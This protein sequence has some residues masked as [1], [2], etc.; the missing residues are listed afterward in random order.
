MIDFDRYATLSN[1]EDWEAVHAL[2][3]D[4]RAKAATADDRSREIYL[5]VAALKRQHR[6][7]EALDLLRSG[8]HLYNSQSLAQHDTAHV[9][10]KLGCEQDALNVL[11][12]APYETEMTSFPLLAMDAKFFHLLLLAKGGD[13]SVKARLGEIPDDY[14]HV[15]MDGD[16]VR[17][18]DIIAL[19][20][21]G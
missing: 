12:K 3:D 11:S 9:L 6:Y 21:D 14:L 2:L 15:T 5:R 8:G 16:L 7:G 17:K 18:S 10:L 1:R 20:D 4:A 13:S 19:Q